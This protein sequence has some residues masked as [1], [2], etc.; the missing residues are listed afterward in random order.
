MGRSKTSGEDPIRAMVVVSGLLL[1]QAFSSLLAHA[2]R[3]TVIA[4][5]EDLP[6]AIRLLRQ[7]QPDVIV[8]GATRPKVDPVE[9]VRV[10][11]E[12]LH[13]NIPVV[14]LTRHRDPQYLHRALGSP[15]AA[16]VTTDIS[17]KALI[18]VL[19]VVR[20]GLMVLGGEAREAMHHSLRTSLP[21]GLKLA[22]VSGLTAREREVLEL[23]V[24][25]LTNKEISLRL[26]IGLR[27]A[28][29]HAAS[30]INKMGARS[31]TDAV[32]KALRAILV[33]AYEEAP[34]PMSVSQAVS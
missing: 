22:S 16:W 13:L 5:A 20:Y 4:E 27:T 28:E 9:L 23:M 8:A 24:E 33:P 26:G 6:E 11:N 25:G 21:P 3:V 1:R 7:R 17:P 15:I 2:P 30:V 10:L 34:E 18:A 32:V 12:D 29:M 31:R 19:R 14:V